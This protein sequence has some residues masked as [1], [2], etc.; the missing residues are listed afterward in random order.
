MTPLHPSST[1]LHAFIAVLSP[2]SLIHWSCRSKGAPAP[3]QSLISRGLST[4]GDLPPATLLQSNTLPTS[5]CF[6]LS[7]ALFPT[8]NTRYHQADDSI[9]GCISCRSTAE[10]T[11]HVQPSHINTKY[12]TSDS[13]LPSCTAPALSWLFD[14]RVVSLLPH[15]G[16]RQKNGA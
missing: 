15:Q 7:T 9:A 13:S 11:Y 1:T 2:Y 8:E 14:Y 6:S 5:P 12:L 3:L 16:E 10:S 4:Y